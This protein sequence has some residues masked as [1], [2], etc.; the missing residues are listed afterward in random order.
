ML[1]RRKLQKG[2]E[3]GQSFHNATLKAGTTFTQMEESTNP[4]IA[5]GGPVAGA[6]NRP[7]LEKR[8]R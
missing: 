3:E 6:E 2:K 7:H 8:G 4:R 5:T 1:S